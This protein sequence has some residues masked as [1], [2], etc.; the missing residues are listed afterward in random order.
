M[1][2]GNALTVRDARHDDH[3]TIV[4]FNADLAWE[5]EHKR[6]D[7]DVLRAGVQSALA[8]PARLRYWVAEVDG[9]VAGQAAISRE[10]SDWR[11]GWLWWFQSVY[12]RPEDRGRG[13]FRALYRHVRD[14]ARRADDVVGLRLYVETENARAQA[15]YRAL[16]MVPGGYHVYEELWIS[17]TP[18]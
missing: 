8:D 16:G 5:T 15:T 3:E 2:Q 10:W 17:P 11:N 14:E 4:A 6:L 18:G 1:A 9:R 12:V 7:H 13:V